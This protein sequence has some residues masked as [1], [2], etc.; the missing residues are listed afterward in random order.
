[1]EEEEE[2]EEVNKASFGN[3]TNVNM[4]GWFATGKR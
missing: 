3:F 2:E 4:Q 1:M